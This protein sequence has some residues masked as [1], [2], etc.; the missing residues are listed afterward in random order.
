MTDRQISQAGTDLLALARIVSATHDA[1]DRLVTVLT[2]AAHDEL[3]ALAT[4]VPTADAA[5]AVTVVFV[6]QYS[7]GKSS[8][9]K[10]LTGLDIEI[11]ADIATMRATTYPWQG[12]LIVDTPGVRTGEHEAH[13]RIT[14]EALR[15]A[16]AV[17]FV[18]TAEGF[19]DVAADYFTLLRQRL[20]T[21][22]QLLLVV[23]KSA[24]EGSDPA[25][26]EGHLREVLGELF[27]LIPVVRTDARSWLQAEDFPQPEQRRRMSG[28]RKLADFLDETVRAR[29]AHLRLATPLRELAAYGRDAIDTMSVTAGGD[30]LL[31]RLDEVAGAIAEQRQQMNESVSRAAEEAKAFVASKLVELGPDIDEDQLSAVAD[32][33]QKQFDSVL[34]ADA[35]RTSENV[36][37]ALER[38]S[39][40]PRSEELAVPE[41]PSAVPAWPVI[42]QQI[43]RGLQSI[44]RDFG[45]AGAR[46]GGVGNT[47]VKQIWHGVGRK[48]PPW[49]AV[50]AAEGTAKIA[51]VLGPALVIG[52]AAFG[53]WQEYRGAQRARQQ[54]DR[55]RGWRPK[56]LQ[57]AEEMVGPWAASARAAVMERC[58]QLDAVI[59]RQRLSVLAKQAAGDRDVAAL[60]AVNHLLLELLMQLEQ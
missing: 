44:A 13:D 3:R 43:L 33:A 10:C 46:P 42:R 29:G 48:F 51:R 21:L 12:H 11:G 40:K 32:E 15:G 41:Q 24:A 18:A 60:I 49:G 5:D 45:G 34:D 22:S 2:N 59:A 50:K 31:S 53:F 6:G 56:A 25:Q 27:D 35:E 4:D 19:D 36:G 37:S 47:A 39:P 54:A 9:I 52:E 57:I 55:S 30:P 17:V 14:E 8:L 16:D 38:Y 28:I 58:D 1:R 20:R 26:V 7:A 23:N